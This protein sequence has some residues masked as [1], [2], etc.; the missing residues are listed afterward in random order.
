MLTNYVKIAVRNIKRN[1]LYSVISILGLAI[2]ITGAPLLYLY[3]DNELSHDAFH[4]KSDRIYRIV[5][6][7]ENGDQGTRY[8]GQTAPVLGATLEDAHPELQEVVR[9][10]RPVGHIDMKWRGERVHER[11]Y[12]LADPEFFEVFDFEF[13]KGD[14]TDPLAQPNTVVLTKRK[15][16]QLFGEENPVGKAL[17]INNIAP[18]TVTAVIENVPDNSHLQFDYLISRQNTQYDMSVYLNDWTAYGAY[19]YLLLDGS[20]D[21]DAFRSKMDSFINSQQQA[22]PN[23]RNFYLQPLT[24]IYFN[25]GDIEFGLEQE[26]GN[27]FYIYVFSAI[28]VFLLLIAGINYM[29]LATALSARRGREIGIRKSAGAERKQLVFQFLSESVVIALIA[30]IISYFLIELTLPFFN[31]LTGKHFVLNLETAASIVGVLAGFGIV[32]GVASGSYPAFYLALIDPVRVLKSKFDLKGKNLTLRR[33]LVVTQFT[34]SIVLIIGTLG[35]YRQ[36]NYIQTA[37]LG[38]DTDQTLIVDINHGNTRARFDAMKQELEKLPGVVDAATSSRVPGERWDIEQV[39]ARSLESGS[40]D[41]TQTYFMSFDEDMLGLY[42][43]ELEAGTNFTGNKGIDSL[44]VLLNETAVRALDLKDPVGHYLEISGAADQIKVVGV[45]EDFH[46]QS[47]HRHIAPL[48]IGYWSNPIRVIDYF[49]IKLAGNDLQGIIQN[50]KE[51]HQQF[52]PE[53]AMEYRF[54]DQQIEQKY[55]ADIRA[56]RLFGIGGGVTIFIAC[57]G[58]FGLA[59][60]ATETRIREVGIRKVLGAS[61]GDILTLLTGDFV[62]LVALAFLLAVPVAWLVMNRWL[63]KF[64]YHTELGIGIF[65]LAGAVAL[66][67]SVATISWQAVR[68]AQAKPVESLRSE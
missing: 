57:M 39:Y 32:L 10:Y 8:V 16:K 4:E 52:D 54:L 9:L 35:V 66:L 58:L 20:A 7:S 40:A 56:G 38:F 33:V 13:L 17:P 12:L 60:L 59:L 14:Q 65:L 26:Q 1:A 48:I 28:G 37:D 61:V 25:S 50:I 51:V 53:T 27:K 19:T 64:A 47:L 3:I 36:M 31:E 11:N 30:C 43:L 34:L 5:E 6:I 15:A 24:N 21:V 44:T 22:N 29:N 23:F 45:L 49:S 62:K 42:D 63:D 55:Q 46:Y 67:L 68:A 2:G 18:V 41:S